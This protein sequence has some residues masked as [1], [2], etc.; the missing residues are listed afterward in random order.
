MDDRFDRLF[1]TGLRCGERKKVCCEILCDRGMVVE[2]S[3]LC[4]RAA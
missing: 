4:G 2:M 3:E 1:D